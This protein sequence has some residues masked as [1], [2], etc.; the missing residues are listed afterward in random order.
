MLLALTEKSVAMQL[1]LFL[2]QLLLSKPM[3]RWCMIRHVAFRLPTSIDTIDGS[4]VD[5]N[6]CLLRRRRH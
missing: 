3:L 6:Y 2:R 4:T 1:L 5:I